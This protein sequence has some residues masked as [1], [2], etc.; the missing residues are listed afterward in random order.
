[1]PSAKCAKLYVLFNASPFRAQPGRVPSARRISRS[2][3]LVCIAAR[4]LSAKTHLGYG[5]SDDRVLIARE[6][7]KHPCSEGSGDGRDRIL[8]FEEQFPAVFGSTFI[9]YPEHRSCNS[10]RLR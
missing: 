1:M 7:R 3:S 5:R 4:I 10:Q 8:V 9:H 2:E 6:S